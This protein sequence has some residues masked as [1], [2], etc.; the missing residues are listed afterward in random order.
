MKW[1]ERVLYSMFPNLLVKGSRWE[2]IWIEREREEFLFTARVFFP[3]AAI[4]YAG[5]YFF[6]DKYLGLTPLDHWFR[7]RFSMAGLA[8]LGLLFYSIPKLYNRS[9]YKI[10][11]LLVVWVFC[12]T[13]ARVS[14]WYPEAPYLFAYGFVFIAAMM[15]RTSA[16]KSAIFAMAIIASQSPSFLEAGVSTHMI[17]S[18]A[19]VVIIFIVFS[20][21]NYQDEIQF[22]IANLEKMDAQKKIIELNLEFTNQIK[23][24]LPREIS[25]RLSDNINMKRMSVIQAIDD[26]LRPRKS[27]VACMYSDI[28]GFT[29][30]TKNLD[31][32]ISQGVLPNVKACTEAIEESGGIPRKIGDLIFS[33][34][35]HHES[36]V[37][38]INSLIAAGSVIDINRRF[39]EADPH[40]IQIKRHVLI[41]LGEAFVGNLG[42][43][44][45]SIEITALGSPVNLLSRIDELT[46]S[47]KLQGILSADDVILDS[48]AAEVFKNLSLGIEL[49]R[50]ALGEL[51]LKIRDFP[52]VQEIYVVRMAKENFEKIYGL[53]TFMETASEEMAA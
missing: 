41:S 50:I 26:V 33:Y 49:R 53:Y 39:N 7:F 44:N 48:N 21:V 28:R 51:E 12:Y 16:L 19:V 23:A 34:Y 32:Y 31:G 22:F 29:Q 9:G 30:G 46:K 27:N 6:F 52:E 45:S 13:Q 8:I 4:V 18:A 42:S 10:P 15:I 40:G 1:L 11:M 47:E 24:F 2:S 36:R 3:I 20:R 43:Y 25:K 37:N 38:L 5:H 35:D 14:V 17:L